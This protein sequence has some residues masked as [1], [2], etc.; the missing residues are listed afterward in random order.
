MRIP[1]SESVESGAKDDDLPNPFFDRSRQS[2]FRNPASRGGADVL[3]FLKSSYLTPMRT[4][5]R[6]PWQNGT[7]ERWVGSARRELPD[8]VIPLNE[9]HLRRLGRDYVAYY[10]QDRSHIGLNKSTPAKRV[11]ETRSSGRSHLIS[12]RDWVVFVIGT[13]GLKRRDRVNVYE[14]AT[15]F[16]GIL[17]P[18][19]ATMVGSRLQFSV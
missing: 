10:H 3:N 17:E 12:I 6:S 2:I 15:N 1:E 5:I 13:S 11:V 14:Q 18:P 19:P 8:H 7:A 16:T 9:Y 4:S